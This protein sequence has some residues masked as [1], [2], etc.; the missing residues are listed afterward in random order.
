MNSIKH[1]DS[2]QLNTTSKLAQGENNDC[3]VRAFTYA[4][5]IPYDQSHSICRRGFGRKNR[6]GTYFLNNFKTGKALIEKETGQS[7]IDV[8]PSLGRKYYPSTRKIRK[9][10]IGTF[11]KENN[12]G[13]YLVLIRRHMFTIKEGVVIGNQVDAERLRAR[14]VSLYEVVER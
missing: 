12:P 6:K 5:D 9:K 2:N 13:T 8:T 4:F 3:V 10:T 1:I 14:I 11:I 7:L